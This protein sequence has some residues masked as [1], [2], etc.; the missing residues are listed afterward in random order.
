MRSLNESS[1]IEI[2]NINEDHQTVETIITTVDKSARNVTQED[3][4]IEKEGLH[5]QRRKKNAR[6]ESQ[7]TQ[8][9][10]GQ[11]RPGTG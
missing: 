9:P 3:I 10:K 7:N 2:D 8:N 1:G 4:L 11:S 5:V 6:P